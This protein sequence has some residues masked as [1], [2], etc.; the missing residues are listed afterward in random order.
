MLEVAG[1]RRHAATKRSLSARRARVPPRAA[2][3]QLVG[4][5]PASRTEHGPRGDSARHGRGGRLRRGALTRVPSLR[6]V[7]PDRRAGRATPPIRARPHNARV[8]AA[9][10]IQQSAAPCAGASLPA[11]S[12]ARVAR[13]RAALPRPRYRPRLAPLRAHS[14]PR[15]RGRGGRSRLARHASGAARHERTMQHCPLHVRA[16]GNAAPVAS[17]A[18]RARRSQQ[19]MPRGR[20]RRTTRPRS[21]CTS[22]PVSDPPGAGRSGASS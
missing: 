6:R 4:A 11:R 17:R 3:T 16:D 19:P 12:A 9:A 15:G 18:S 7:G 22:R 21:V 5:R 2:R 20:S 13:S 10:A 1:G 8:H 14:R